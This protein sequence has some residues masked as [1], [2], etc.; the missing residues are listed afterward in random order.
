[1]SGFPFSLPPLSRGQ[2]C[3]IRKAAKPKRLKIKGR[4]LEAG[5][6]DVSI[7]GRCILGYHGS[8]IGYCSSGIVF[9]HTMS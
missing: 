6:Y 3:H 2:V 9:G 5:N 7:R 8:S 1:M 4:G